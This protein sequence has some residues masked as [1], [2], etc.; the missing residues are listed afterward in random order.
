MNRYDVTI[1]GSGLGGLECALVLSKEGMKVCVIEKNRQFGG[2]F[3]SFVR[4]GHTIDSSI[5]Y[6]GSLDKGEILHRYFSYFGIMES[7]KVERLNEQGYDHI[8]LEGDHYSFAMGYDNFVDSLSGQFPK[9]HKSVKR[10]C[11]SIKRVGA[12]SSADALKTG[13]FSR[14]GLDY[15]TQSAAGEIARLTSDRQL[16]SVLWGTSLLYG[17]VQEVTPFYLHAITNNSNI[18]GAYRFKG[19]SHQVVD[20]LVEEIGKNGGTL[21]NNSEVSRIVVENEMLKGVVTSNNEMIESKYVISNLHPASTLKLTDKNNFIRKSYFTRI[22]ANKNTYGLFCLYLIMKPS[23]IKYLNENHYIRIDSGKDIYALVSMQPPVKNSDYAEVITIVTPMYFPELE[24]WS[25]TTVEHRGEDYVNFKERRA[26][27]LVDSV[28]FCFPGLKESVEYKYTA[29]PLTFRD[30]TANPDGS[31]YGIQKNYLNPYSTLL[32]PRTRVPNL[33]LTGQNLN[34]HGVL[35]VTITSMLTC[36][37]IIKGDYL[38]KKI[39][40]L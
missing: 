33:L 2:L 35:G 26:E 40:S 7:L 1:V 12:L 34:V 17:G 11:D 14:N 38:A 5:H 10:Y 28:S 29:T 36:A 30:Y 19:G 4:E 37:E 39:G 20:A 24:K 18:Q 32:S 3:Q 9:E 27:E 25:E 6:V 8:H 23:R 15:F 16:Q 13:I 21:M 31:A 22:N